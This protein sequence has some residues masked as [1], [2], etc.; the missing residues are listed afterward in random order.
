MNPGKL[1]YRV[2]FFRRSGT[3]AKDQRG[4]QSRPWVHVAGP[5]WA[6]FEVLSGRV[7]PGPAGQEVAV[8]ARVGVR[9]EEMPALLQGDAVTVVDSRTPQL[10]FLVHS[11]GPGKGARY[12]LNEILLEDL[13]EQVVPT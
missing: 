9:N 1:R 8:T 3:V 13:D 11:W 6:D 2:S 7:R 12:W 10:G 4:R 5:V